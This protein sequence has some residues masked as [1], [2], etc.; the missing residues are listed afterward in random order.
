M[1]DTK[2]KIVQVSEQ[3]FFEMG[4]ANV[5]LQQIADAAEISVG[6]LAYHYNNKEAIVFAVYENLFTQLSQILS[7]FIVYQE[8]DGFDKQFSALYHFYSEN[9]FTYNN[10]WEIE[11]NYPEIQS[12]W[13]STMTKITLQF[14]KRLE[15][16]VKSGYL[17]PELYKGAYDAL[18]QNLSLLSHSILPQQSL[19]KKTVKEIEYK[20][21][22]WSLLIPVFTEKGKHFFERQVSPY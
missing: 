15:F 8:L 13:L 20:R 12:E 1:P 7:Q 6:N 22:L 16:N 3:L 21:L 17:K 2:L 10:Q 14:K 4:I 9:N 19:R 11:R 18:S 5:R